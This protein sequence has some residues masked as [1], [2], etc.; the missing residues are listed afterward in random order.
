MKV[1]FILL[2]VAG[3]FI[4]CKKESQQQCNCGLITDDRVSD[5]SVVIRN[6]CSGNEKRFILA[7]GDWINAHVGDDYCITNVGSW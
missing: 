2:L 6:S 5:Y 1:V 7:P 3:T 4:S